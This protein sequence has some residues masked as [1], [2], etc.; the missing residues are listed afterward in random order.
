MAGEQIGFTFAGRTIDYFGSKSITSDNTA[1]FELVKNSRD[2]SASKVTIHFKDIDTKNAQIE[3]YDDGDGMSRDDV[4]KKWFV[5]GTDSRLHNNRTRKGKPVWGEMGIG[6]MA[7]QKLGGKTVMISVKNSRRIAVEFDWSRFE[8]PG[9]TVDQVK[10]S[11]PPDRVANDSESGVT[12]YL[13]NLKSRWTAKKIRDFMDEVSLLISQ[14]DIEDINVSVK[15]GKGTEERVGKDYYKLL[16]HVVD[17]APFKARVKFDGEKLDLKIFVQ[18]GQRG[19]W[20]DQEPTGIY[21]D[22][23]VGPFTADIY[24]FPRAPG[25]AKTA[26]IEKYYEHRIGVDILDAFVKDKYGLYLY[27]DGAWMR[28]YGGSTDWLGLEAAAR[29]ETTKIGLKQIY[30]T[31]TMTKKKNPEIKPASHRETLI[32]NKAYKD[33]KRIMGDVFEM[34][35]YYMRDWK[36]EEQKKELEDMGGGRVED[37]D[38]TIDQVLTK[39]KNIGRKL[40]KFEKERFD[41]YL[42]GYAQVSRMRD[43]GREREIAEM[44]EMRDWE[45]NLATLGIASSF[46]ARQVTEALQ[47]NMEISQEAEQMMSEQEGKGWKISDADKQKGYEMVE[48]LKANQ[49]KMSHFMSFVDVF[50]DHLA[51]SIR[52]K[53]RATQVN[54]WKCWDTVAKGFTD[55]KD[56]LEITVMEDQYD[57]TVKMDTIDL[58]SV[59]THLYMN[60]I[61]S[62]ERTKGRKRKVVFDYDY[63]DGGL[64]IKFSDNGIGIPVKKLVE[65]FEPFKFGH[66][67]DDE[68]KHGHGLGLHIV[69]KIMEHYGGTAEAVSRSQGVT[70][71]LSF[72]DIKK[73]AA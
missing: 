37:L 32:E 43:E 56:E 71:I 14:D 55:I 21:D 28:P 18:V 54:V 6:R 1:L 45:K 61:Q 35:R 51:K 38:L 19:S 13:E 49:A 12:L 11:M 9:T 39:I 62:L 23:E 24:H 41:R 22:T 73:V 46:M 16:K 34:L 69:K 15:V 72:P 68:E 2:A 53:K 36:K 58:E 8:K 4:R 7:C 25:K 67:E 64:T 60:S 59:L 10:F 33:L 48:T 44:G 17:N 20:E 63:K 47:A 42:G 57:L 29:Q 5:V 50:S 27:R 65:V 26:T 66:N 3:V 31:V 52:N 40:P 70:I 30:G